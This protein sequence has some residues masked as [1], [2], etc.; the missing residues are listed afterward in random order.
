VNAALLALLLLSGQNLGQPA[1]CGVQ[2]LRTGSD[3]IFKHGLTHKWVCDRL[4]GSGNPVLVSKTWFKATCYATSSTTASCR[5]FAVADPALLVKDAAGPPVWKH[6]LE[7]AALG[8]A[9]GA[10]VVGCIASGGCAAMGG[11]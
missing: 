10:I 1:T 7:D 8:A 4:P 5:D 6:R 3:A 2:Q 11:G 9:V